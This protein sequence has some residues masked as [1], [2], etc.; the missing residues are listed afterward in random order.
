MATST[1]INAFLAEVAPA[2]R[3]AAQQ[4]KGSGLDVNPEDIAAQ[5]AYETGYGTSA[6]AKQNNYG[7]LTK[8][9]G[10]WASY[11]SIG[12]FVNEYVSFIKRLVITENAQGIDFAN[13]VQN[14]RYVGSDDPNK[15]GNYARTVNSIANNFK[16][17]FS[18]V[19]STV[20]KGLQTIGLDPT[21]TPT[22]SPLSPSP[23]SGDINPGFTQT[24]PTP[25]P[26]PS[27]SLFDRITAT[28]GKFF[29]NLAYIL[30]ALILFILGIYILNSKKINETVAEKTKQA[31]KAAALL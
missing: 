1:Q 9:G 5:W 12:D 30:L 16:S 23:S 20:N 13:K 2:A 24:T 25:S 17:F 19:G 29:T 8:S 3:Y 10:G 11:T 21:P 14:S 27:T 6:L 26:T 15:Y 4:L 28:I 7:G 31:A 22:P 18:T